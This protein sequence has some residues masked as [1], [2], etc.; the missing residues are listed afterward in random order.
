MAAYQKQFKRILAEEVGDYA[1][2]VLGLL[3]T[4]R[5]H[6]QDGPGASAAQV[7][8]WLTASCG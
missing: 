2:R 8:P 5:R 4:V 6:S 1:A 7:A 3:Q